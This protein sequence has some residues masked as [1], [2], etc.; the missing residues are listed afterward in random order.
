MVPTNYLIYEIRP[1]YT[2]YY[3]CL[4]SY[5]DTLF[6]STEYLSLPNFPL[7]SNRPRKEVFYVC[8][9]FDVNRK[10]RRQF[11]E[12]RVFSFNIKHTLYR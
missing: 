3:I 10:K 9:H 4:V 1:P 2:Y 11:Q 12:N 6:C 7:L 8:Y 5:I